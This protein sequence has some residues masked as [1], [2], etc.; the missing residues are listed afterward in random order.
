MAVG[1]DPRLSITDTTTVIK[2]VSEEI[3]IADPREAPLLK[4]ISPN[5]DNLPVPCESNP[6]YWQTDIL[7]PLSIAV[8][9]TTGCTAGDETLYVASGYGEYFRKGGLWLTENA[10]VVWAGATTDA[11][12]ALDT[13]TIV[14]GVGASAASSIDT[15]TTLTYV[16]QATLENESDWDSFYE[17]PAQ[18]DNRVQIFHESV[19]VSLV[20]QATA[21]Y[22]MSNPLDYHTT[23][24]LPELMRGMN[25]AL[26]HGWKET[27]TATV[28]GT[29][30][31]LADTTSAYIYSAFRNNKASAALAESDIEALMEEMFPYIG[32]ANMPTILVC[33]SWAKRKIS[34][35]WESRV[36]IDRGENEVG[37]VIDR[38]RTDFG[39]LDVLLDYLCPNNK[40][41][42]LN[43]KHIGVGPL[44]GNGQ[45]L[46]F[47]WR[48][49]SN[50]KMSDLKVLY[51]AYT[52]YWG[53][54]KVHGEIYSFSTTT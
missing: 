52:V 48:Q 8:S 29:F 34:S 22:G 26:Y 24:R 38:I 41:Y 25:R 47:A 3:L 9:D 2:S 10:E 35:W 44:R 36:R 33:N 27:A 51:G 50:S 4:T 1:L 32:A 46:S 19:D 11:N 28:A 5:L 40:I 53:N 30:G 17:T 49:P 43:P 15:G 31:G 13:I 42:L 37:L 6:Y 54:P 23:K 45:D 20:E 18:I 21:R 16:G 7:A 14:R 12:K 39:D